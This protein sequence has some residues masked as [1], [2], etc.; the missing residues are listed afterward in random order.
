MK[1]D[2]NNYNT[3]GDIDIAVRRR[4]LRELITGIVT[5]LTIRT[6]ISRLIKS[7]KLGQKGQ[8]RERQSSF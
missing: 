2:P 5:P 7:Q 6:T 1:H 8:L 3:N 4:R